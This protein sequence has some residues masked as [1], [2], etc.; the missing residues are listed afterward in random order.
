MSYD[1]AQQEVNKMLQYRY[2]DKARERS[3]HATRMVEQAFGTRRVC[4]L[5]HDQLAWVGP[6]YDPIRAYVCLRCN[7]MASEPEIKDRG[8]DFDTIMDVEI[9]KILDLDLKRQAGSNAKLFTGFGGFGAFDEVAHGTP[10]N[11]PGA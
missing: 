3:N 4:P 7:A 6:P 2:A 8:F 5:N 9:L 10:E 1:S 11:L